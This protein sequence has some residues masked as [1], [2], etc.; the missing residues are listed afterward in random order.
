MN[1]TAVAVVGTV[2]SRKLSNG[3]CCLHWP[4]YFLRYLWDITEFNL[5]KVSVHSQ[6]SG[7]KQ[8]FLASLLLP[9]H[10]PHLQ[11]N[12][13]GINIVL[14]HEWNITLLLSLSKVI[15]LLAFSIGSFFLFPRKKKAVRSTYYYKSGLQMMK[16]CNAKTE[17]FVLPFGPV[18]Q[19][20]WGY[21]KLGSS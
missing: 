4:R 14:L 21:S 11:K 6:C 16:Y 3:A 18:T 9:H 7:T 20:I 17:P 8:L 12:I 2:S 19:R 15:Y 5:D 10:K 1:T 13:G